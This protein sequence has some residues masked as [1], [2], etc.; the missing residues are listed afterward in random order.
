MKNK[1]FNVLLALIISFAVWLYVITVVSP[2]YENTYYDVPVILSGEAFLSER[3]LMITDGADA[4]VTLTL[5]GN[6][7]DLMTL[8]RGNID[9][10]VNLSNISSAG[11]QELSYSVG[12]PGHIPGDAVSV[13]VKY[14][15][16]VKLTI[17]E[18]IT[19]TLPV[20]PIWT[21]S[22][23]INDY[24]ADKENVVLDHET[25]TV[26]GP[27][28]IMDRI[29]K[30]IISVDL[31]G[32]T[33]SFSQVYPLLLC[34]N[35]GEPVE[36]D[37]DLVTVSAGEVQLDMKIHRVKEV[38]LTVKVNPG[39]GATEKTSTITIEPHTIK[40]SGS[41]AA[42][43]KIDTIELGEI[44]LGEL[45]KDTE[46]TFPIVLPENVTNV[47]GVT[48]ALVKVSFPALTMKEL[49]VRNIQAIN[50]PEGM[51]VEF[52]NQVINVIVRGPAEK[53]ANITA[54]DIVIIVDFANVE[55]GTATV[56]ARIQI[57]SKY[58]G[59]GEMGTYTVSATLREAIPETT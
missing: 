6:R 20:E 40:I 53:V 34:N 16:K 15:D 27:K 3:D 8:N 56:K 2:G 44:N 14:P 30:A 50:V 21:G 35:A 10:V 1:L 41:E 42:L 47:S 13:Q 4:T 7:T 52:L 48:E 11:V 22:V 38:M 39:G 59:V 51:E 37:S 24:L 29:S 45:S 58:Y 46:L 18:K 12:Y 19:K 54:D 26:T 55:E 31:N 9:L 17:E 25:V 23:P 57:S 43:E 49:A 28:S 36:L 32:R 5:K 33:E